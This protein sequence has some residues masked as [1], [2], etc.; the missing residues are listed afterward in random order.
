[1]KTTGKVVQQVI[2]L[3]FGLLAIVGPIESM[4][5]R[6]GRGGGGFR[7]GGGGFRGGGMSGASFRGGGGGFQRGGANFQRGGFTGANRSAAFTG[8]RGGYRGVNRPVAYNRG[9]YN[10]GY[11]NRGYYNRGFYGNRFYGRRY[12]RP[13]LGFYPAF[14]GGYGGYYGGYP[15]N[16]YGYDQGYY[17]PSAGYSTEQPVTEQ[18]VMQQS[19]TGQPVTE[20]PA[21]WQPAMGQQQALTQLAPGA[22]TV[23]LNGA[24]FYFSCG[25]FFVNDNGMFREVAPPIGALVYN[26]PASAT[27]ET[28]DGT[29]FIV[30]NNVLY[31]PIEVN[32]RT[33]FQ[34]TRTR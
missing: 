25:A 31:S 28:I 7:G 32:G 27:Q 21:N 8:Y 10:R 6:G 16:D 15:Y 34:V 12:Y 23:N 9:F 2:A 22:E 20:Q 26:L 5:Q 33:A 24:E 17:Q 30:F 3:A 14:Y 13:G 1:M 19:M 29:L 11:Y 18:P 4:A